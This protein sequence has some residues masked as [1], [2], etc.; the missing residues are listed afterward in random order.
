MKQ[1]V[2][3]SAVNYFTNKINHRTTVKLFRKVIYGFLVLYSLYLLGV[4][5]QL[6]S[7]KSLIAPFEI[8]PSFGIFN[9]LQNK[10]IG[11]YYYIFFIGQF[12]FIGLFFFGKLKRLSTIAI[13]FFTVNLLN[14]IYLVTEGG[15]K[16]L[17]LFLFYLVFIDEDEEIG[18]DNSF[19]IFNNVV[20]NVFILII[21]LQVVLVYLFSGIYKLYGEHWLNGEAIYYILSIDEFS[22][23]WIQSNFLQAGW[24]MVFSN[25]LVLIYQLSF[26]ILVWIKK[27]K[28]AVLLVG[29]LFHLFISLA[30]GLFDFGIIMILAYVIYFPENWSRRIMRL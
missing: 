1:K 22:H 6:F 24:L 15:N 25:Y 20:S 3:D 23:P 26:P 29:V 5:S 21:Q 12:F 27:I 2:F 8:E 30:I 7:E 9:L 17:L 4:S 28:P 13:Y 14:R 16:L 10:F 18:S 19:N 11:K